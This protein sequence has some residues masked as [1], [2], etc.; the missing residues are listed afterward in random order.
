MSQEHDD[1]VKRVPPERTGP[2]RYIATAIRP[3]EEGLGYRPPASGP[4]SNSAVDSGVDTA[5]R[6]LDEYLYRGRQAAERISH[7][8]PNAPRGMP[9]MN[10]NLRDFTMDAARMWN[11]M[12]WSW[13]ELLRPPWLSPPRG[14]PGP[15]GEAPP[16]SAWPPPGWSPSHPPHEGPPGYRPWGAPEPSYGEPPFPGYGY[17]PGP[18]ATGP[19]VRPAEG[20]L[21]VGMAIQVVLE[22]LQGQKR[23]SVDVKAGLYPNAKVDQLMVQELRSITSTPE[24]GARADNTRGPGTASLIDVRIMRTGINSVGCNVFVPA[25]QPAGTYEAIIY[26]PASYSEAGPEGSTAYA[27]TP[28]GST[29]F[30]PVRPKE[31]GWLRVIIWEEDSR[32]PQAG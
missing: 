31:R 9:T 29:T 20:T 12:L 26:E 32:D 16:S 7:H 30:G 18:Y 3:P 8:P 24:F 19:Q 5:Y 22:P 10:R 2:I 27:S 23:R 4:V 21:A 6:V 13:L 14:Y 28:L 25:A 17:P 11:Y 1:R 15:F